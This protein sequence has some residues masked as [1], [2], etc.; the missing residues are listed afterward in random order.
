M[1]K[2]TPAGPC[3]TL[4]AE[5]RAEVERQLGEQGRLTIQRGRVDEAAPTQSDDRDAQGAEQMTPRIAAAGGVRPSSR[6]V[7]ARSRSLGGR[8]ASS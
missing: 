7:T 6:A 8:P 5:Q 3:R 4:S 2:K 1:R